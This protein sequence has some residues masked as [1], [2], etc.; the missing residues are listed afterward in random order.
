[1]LIPT[2]S[3]F[4]F[5]RAPPLFP[6]FTAASVWIKDSMGNTSCLERSD[7]KFIFLAFAETIPAVT[8]E[9]KLKG[10]PTAKTHSPTFKSSLFPR[11]IG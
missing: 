5:T 4:V 9:V 2:N 8:V 10:F 7:N 11:G 6:G 1:V 3:P